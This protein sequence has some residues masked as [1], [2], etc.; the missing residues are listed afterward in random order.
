MY[1]SIF[2][3]F[4]KDM[5]KRPTKDHSIERVKNNKDYSPTNC[6]WASKKDQI[7]NRSSSIYIIM[8]SFIALCALVRDEKTSNA[9]ASKTQLPPN[10]FY[11]VHL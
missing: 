5:G 4:Y 7:K 6:I 11:H 9:S 8:Y 10:S 1:I 2:E 3:N